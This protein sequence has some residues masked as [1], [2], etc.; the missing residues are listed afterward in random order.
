MD[1]VDA[2]DLNRF[3]TA[4]A[5]QYDVAIGELRS[6]QK[7]SHWMWYIFPQINGLG[8]SATSKRY[9]ITS[10]DEARAYLNHPILGTRL[11]ACADTLLSIDGRSA[12][13]IFGYPDDMKLR[14]SMTLFKQ[15]AGANSIFE[16]VLNKYFAG[17]DDNATKQIWAGLG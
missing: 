16:L 1:S 7:R 2:F 9:A 17:T 11:T 13:E 3:L 15:V 4:Q 14:S 5:G 10:A 6:G 12:A 8:M